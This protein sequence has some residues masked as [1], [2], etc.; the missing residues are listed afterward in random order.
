MPDRA[1]GRRRATKARESIELSL[2]RLQHL[3]APQR[4]A[5]VLGD[6]LGFRT[7]E[8][9]GMLDTGEGS[10]KGALQPPRDAP[11]AAAGRR[12]RARAA[13]ELRRRAPTGRRFADALQSGDI[14]D[15]VA[16]LTDDALL[17]MPPQ[18]LEYEGH[19]AIAA[20]CAS[21]RSCATRRCV[22]C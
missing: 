14:D 18:P 10:V 22:S 3:A 2:R 20:S 11:S 4:A 7:A 15:M 9:A 13:A 1:R 19:D 16:L 17:T 12:P 6:V 21:E 5:L 8:V